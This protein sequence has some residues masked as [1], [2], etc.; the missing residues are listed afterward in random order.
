M[1]L[2]QLM[3]IATALFMFWLFAE[4]G[5]HKLN[6][7][8]ELYFSSL[9][10]EFGWANLKIAALIAK[11]VGLLELAIAVAIVI[12]ATRTTAAIIAGNVLFI[13]MLHMAFQ[14]YRG[15]RDLDCGCAGPA[16]QLK[17]SGHLVIRNLL[18][19]A[20]TFF[21]LIPADNAA[22]MLWLLGSLLAIVGIFINLSSEQLIGNAQK[23]QALRN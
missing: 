10:K 11:L 22:M 6:P 21:C 18:L 19:V 9:I 14:L 1:A 2:L 12:P 8:N 23:L 7:A 17:M 16:G 4:A 3:S 13:Y 5:L 15:R 20:A